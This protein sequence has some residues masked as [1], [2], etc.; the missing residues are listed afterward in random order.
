[1]EPDIKIG[2]T[3]LLLFVLLLLGRG[4]SYGFDDG[5]N[6]AKKIESSHFSIYY[7]P[8]VDSAVLAQQLNISPS[9]QILAGGGGR[10]QA[11]SLGLGVASMVDTLFARVC[12]ILDMQLYSYKGNIKVCK[13]QARLEALYKNIFDKPF[14]KESFY[15][16][17]LNTI[18]ISEDNFKQEILG[19]EIG[20]AVISHY[21]V[22]SPSVKIQ[23]VL[24]GYVEYQLRR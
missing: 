13:N 7:E 9:D 22:V 2:K 3:V 21:F 12:D 6:S 1:M 19:H 18:Y 17:D 14:N 4:I 24:A 5:F 23:E 16:N 15:I 8:D 20:H 10:S 11:S